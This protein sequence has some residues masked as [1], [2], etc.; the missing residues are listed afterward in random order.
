MNKL[1]YTCATDEEKQYRK[2]N[3]LQ[4]MITPSVKH[5][6]TA[7]LLV[8]KKTMFETP[9]VLSGK[10]TKKSWYV[11]IHVYVCILSVLQISYNIIQQQ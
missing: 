9:I 5:K 4:K 3:T 10:N 8:S 7:P 11:Y 6:K 2:Y 1:Y